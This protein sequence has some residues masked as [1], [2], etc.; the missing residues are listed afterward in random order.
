MCFSPL[1]SISSF[2]I[3]IIGALLCYNLGTST[4]KLVAGIYGFASLMQGIEYL[5]WKNQTC[6][7]INK[8]ISLFGMILNHLQPI[9]LC[10]L[11]LI[12]NKNLSEI[13]K[14]IILFFTFIYVIIISLYSYQIL[15]NNE[16]TIK[17]EYNHLEWKWHEMNYRGI[18][19]NYFVFI[20]VL[21][22]F[23]GTPNAKYGKILGLIA[24]I[25]YLISFFVY[26]QKR[27]I[28]SLWCLFSAFV[29]FAWFILRKIDLI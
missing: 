20:I 25:T 8:S 7:N 27:V 19:Y 4:D 14:K 21:Q 24:L 29:P 15:T 6:N 18:I 16:C 26:R 17:N 12:L 23:L 9:I 5:L 28:G 10:I 3:G 22:F 13:N 11:I 1:A 2:I